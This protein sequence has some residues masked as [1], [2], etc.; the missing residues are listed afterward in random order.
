MIA[1][2][3]S[4]FPF[5][6]QILPASTIKETIK[7]T[8][9]TPLER[10]CTSLVHQYEYE[11]YGD[12]DRGL[13]SAVEYSQDGNLLA[14]AFDN[15][16]DI[17][18]TNTAA[19]RIEDIFEPIHR[20]Q[21]QETVASLSFSPNNNYL[22]VCKKGGSLTIFYDIN[23]INDEITTKINSCFQQ[24][25][26]ADPYYVTFSPDSK[27][28]AARSG[29]RE[30]SIYIDSNKESINNDNALPSFELL[31]RIDVGRLISPIQ[32]HTGRHTIQFSPGSISLAIG[33]NDGISIYNYT[34]RKLTHEIKVNSGVHSIKYSNNGQFLAVGTKDGTLL[35]YSAPTYKYVQKCKI[36]TEA[37]ELTFSNS[38]NFIAMGFYNQVLIY[39]YFLDAIIY[40]IPIP[41]F[42][43]DDS[44]R[45]L[46]FSADDKYLTIEY[47]NGL[48]TFE[49]SNYKNTLLQSQNISRC[50]GEIPIYSP[51]GTYLVSYDQNMLEML[52]FLDYDN[53]NNLKM[54][55]FLNYYNSFELQVF[56][57]YYT[58][59]TIE[60]DKSPFYIIGGGRNGNNNNTLSFSMDERY[61]AFFDF[62]FGDDVMVYDLIEE[63]TVTIG[64]ESEPR[65]EI[66]KHYDELMQAKSTKN[67]GKVGFGESIDRPMAI[68]GMEYSPNGKYLV[69]VV[70]DRISK[71]DLRRVEGLNEHVLL[72]YDASNHYT[73]LSSQFMDNDGPM[74]SVSF[75][76][77]ERR[78]AVC[79][80]HTAS[81][82]R[83]ED[84]HSIKAHW[85]EFKYKYNLNKSEFSNDL[86]FLA[87][88]GDGFKKL[89]IHDLIKDSTL[90]SIDRDHEFA[91]IAFSPD[92]KI[93]AIGRKY[94][95][96][97][98]YQLS[99]DIDES[100]EWK[101]YASPIYFPDKCMI[102]KIWFAPFTPNSQEVE[103]YTIF[104]THE[105]VD[106][107]IKDFFITQMKLHQHTVTPPG[108]IFQSDDDQILKL[109]QT[110]KYPPLTRNQEEKSMISIA[111]EEDKLSLL[112]NLLQDNP[113]L[114]FSANNNCKVDNRSNGIMM[115][116]MDRYRLNSL[117]N[118]AGGQFFN[119]STS[120][121]EVD[122]MYEVIMKFAKEQV[123]SNIIVKLLNAGEKDCMD[124]FVIYSSMYATV[125]EPATWCITKLASQ[126]IKSLRREMQPQLKHQI[127][128]RPLAI[129]QKPRSS[130]T[131]WVL[132]AWQDLEEDYNKRVE[133]KV[134]RVLLPNLASFDSLK[135]FTNM[136]D[137][138]PFGCQS[139]HAAIDANWS[140]WAR[141]RFLVQLILYV[142]W[143]II[144]TEFCEM[145]K[146]PNVGEYAWPE[147]FF[148]AIVISGISYFF[149][150]EIRQITVIA[151]EDYLNDWWNIW[152]WIAMLFSIA[153][154]ALRLIPGTC[155]TLNG[156]ISA[157]SLFSSWIGLLYHLRG[158][159]SCAWISIALYRIGKSLCAFILVV[160]VVIFSFTLALH[161]L[162][163]IHGSST[164]T[165]ALSASPVEP[166]SNFLSSLR[167]T[168]FASIAGFIDND[169][170]FEESYF[171]GLVS[172]GIL[173]LLFVV[174]YIISHNA[175][176][177]FIGERFDRVLD[178]KNAVLKK[179]KAKVILDLYCLFYDKR[180]KEIENENKWTSLVIPAADLSLKEEPSTLEKNVSRATKEDMKE[181]KK[182]MMDIKKDMKEVNV[183]T[184][185]EMM[186]MKKEVKEMKEVNVETRKEMMGLKKEMKEVNVETKKEI[187]DMKKEVKEVKDMMEIQE[188][189]T[190][191]LKVM[192]QQ[193]IETISNTS[194]EGGS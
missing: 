110:K 107:G 128:P 49:T 70:A 134:L 18:K 40:E 88:L 34:A 16:V 156:C 72:L 6:P 80:D 129:L 138:K 159:E 190:K 189:T 180:R 100:M 188:A 153:I 31:H 162:N 14:V 105:Q 25:S 106:S 73:L 54:L 122:K 28:I 155:E 132:S 11:R 160:M 187:M 176:I 179:E 183:E 95:V 99:Y 83:L 63:R 22:A 144:L 182:E 133:L 151:K 117:S 23:N 171:H 68:L 120:L 178:E 111:V 130:K 89:E 39:D 82:Y 43:T 146:Q 85:K 84:D 10:K 67:S 164:D 13:V 64:P 69:V 1:P 59:D 4:D 142:G 101:P 127:R 104:I 165:R 113:S 115:Y 27:Y 7:E 175:L 77:D 3:S 93:L 33:T 66:R 60:V 48:L 53:Q 32:R 41:N 58:S 74:L 108:L 141:K 185:K 177:A 147:Y 186:G 191:E 125:E 21:L 91:S 65:I 140:N 81:I 154:V 46:T 75:S 20:Y 8:I 145:T 44:M 86:R 9:T 136:S 78:L 158:F 181:M 135:K 45:S 149:C 157:I 161:A 62:D 57:T 76:F 163:D 169:D 30:V 98:C 5:V 123:N 167:T 52:G 24:I 12:K 37:L 102:E 51:Y 50:Y 19:N 166:G 173:I 112:E 109:L 121:I 17:F 36:Y 124:G 137:N 139:L 148:A 192:M 103:F 79:T 170:F 172:Y 71:D 184:K 15:Y 56:K 61:I 114:A 116:L 168:F 26:K 35:L 94:G 92:S 29:I 90:L 47:Q 150:V 87:V 96:V 174:V 42:H 143:L 126:L 97:E 194:K 38:D 55:G 131:E 119:S 2:D 152:Q 118:I 193:I